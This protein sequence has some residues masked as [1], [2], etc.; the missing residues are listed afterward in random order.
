MTLLDTIRDECAGK[1][2]D[3]IR[4]TKGETA[5]WKV[6]KMLRKVNDLRD[7][8]PRRTLGIQETLDSCLPWV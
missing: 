8:M 4:K 3:E 7:R 2:G 1:L 6:S 5:Y